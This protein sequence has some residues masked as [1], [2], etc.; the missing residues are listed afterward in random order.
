MGGQAKR[1]GAHPNG[2]VVGV[3]VIKGVV[4]CVVVEA[5]RVPS[6]HEFCDASHQHCPASALH[7]AAVLVVLL[8]QTEKSVQKAS[9][10]VL[11]V[12][13][14]VC[15]DDEHGPCVSKEKHVELED[16]F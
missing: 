7:P 15:V 5:G 6:L 11:H 9:V 1:L 13:D 10:C 8:M 3:V 4:V 14:G 12:H 16:A 2:V